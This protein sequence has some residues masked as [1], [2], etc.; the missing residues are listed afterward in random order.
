MAQ[1]DRCTRLFLYSWGGGGV[2]IRRYAG[3]EEFAKRAGYIVLSLVRDGV[4]FSAPSELPIVDRIEDLKQSCFE[5]SGMEVALKNLD[6]GKSTCP[7]SLAGHFGPV[8]MNWI[9]LGKAMK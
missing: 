2:G 6:G 8:F 5:K 9:L 3:F 7:R 4:Y 1:I